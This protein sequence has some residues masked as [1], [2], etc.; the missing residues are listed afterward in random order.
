M[1]KP[2]ARY[3]YDDFGRDSDEWDLARP[4]AVPDQPLSIPR[5]WAGHICIAIAHLL[6]RSE[7]EVDLQVMKRIGMELIKLHPGLDD[8]VVYDGMLYLKT[9]MRPGWWEESPPAGRQEEHHA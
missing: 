3:F 8:E 1:T 6:N 7:E 2:E 4:L 5:E 9:I